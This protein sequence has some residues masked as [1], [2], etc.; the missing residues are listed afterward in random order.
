MS[1]TINEDKLLK[2]LAV[3]IVDNPRSTFKEIAESV[4][5]SKA[6][7]HRSCG[8][9]ENLEKLLMEKSH[10]SVES[11]VGIAGKDYDDYEEGVKLLINAHYENQEFLRYI[12]FQTCTD[13]EYW[14]SYTKAL[15]SF[16]LNGQKRG[17]FRI[18]FSVPVLTDFLY[19][20]IFGMIETERKG[21]VASSY[22][23][24]TI[25]KLFLYSTLNKSCNDEDERSEE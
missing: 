22:T 18:D 1:S 5:I 24:E 11:I 16:F 6:T 23:L 9:R 2:L 7:L 19:T 8:T 20:T 21:R 13:D 10:E 3:A 25:E 12:G 17:I 4:G 15:D 14:K